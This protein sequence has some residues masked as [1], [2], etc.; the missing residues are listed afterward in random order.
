[1]TRTITIPPP[2][3]PAPTG[4]LP[5]ILNEIGHAIDRFVASGEPT[6]IDLGGIPMT[7]AEAEALE[8]TLG[9]GEV[10]ARLTA[11]GESEI[12]E[13]GYPGVWRITHLTDSGTPM[14]SFVEITD[15][16]ALLAADAGD[17]AAGR[18]RL[19]RQ[20]DILKRGETQA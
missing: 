17:M 14:A 15:M 3:P 12:R 18:T 13:T 7:P 8:A 6:T 4:N 19:T 9:R 11:S 2:P 20:L 16:P 1:M 5:L 10:E